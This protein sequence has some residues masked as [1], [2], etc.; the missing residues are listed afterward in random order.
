MAH[1]FS[2]KGNDLDFDFNIGRFPSKQIDVVA[3]SGDL[4][5][6]GGAPSII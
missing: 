3:S 4:L 2:S 1:S 5:E 6:Y